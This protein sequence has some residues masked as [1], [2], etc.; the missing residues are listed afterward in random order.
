LEELTFTGNDNIVFQPISDNVE[1]FDEFCKKI[2]DSNEHNFVLMIEEITSYIEF[3]LPEY[4]GRLVRMGRN[5]GIGIIGISQRPKKLGGT[6]PALVD[7]WF[8]FKFDFPADVDFLKQY[9]GEENSE[10]IKNLP[11]YEYLHYD[12][13]N[14]Y[15]HKP[16]GDNNSSHR[17]KTSQE[18]QDQHNQQEK[19]SQKM[20]QQQSQQESQSSSTPSN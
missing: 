2:W 7:D 4:F 17:P 20:S 18:S 14:C 5:R 3:N 15:W 1:K 10:R 11:Q 8:I 13:Y 12:S 16:I 19:Q 9:I 6:F